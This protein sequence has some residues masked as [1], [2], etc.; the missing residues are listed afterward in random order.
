MHELDYHFA[1]ENK[2]LARLAIAEAAGLVVVIVIL[3]LPPASVHFSSPV[4]SGAGVLA[5]LGVFGYLYRQYR[6]APIDKEKY[7][8]LAERDKHA[9]D[10]AFWL[11]ARFGS[12][13]FWKALLTETP[14]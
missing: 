8:L 2:L 3:L 9:G 12:R 1:S 6:S 4:L 7:E 10:Q 5:S 11:N 14:I 13:G